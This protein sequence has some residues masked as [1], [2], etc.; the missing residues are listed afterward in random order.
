MYGKIRKKEK[1]YGKT[2]KYG[3]VQIRKYE[4]KEKNDILRKFC[5]IGIFTKIRSFKTLVPVL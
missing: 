5:N 3:N 2:R 4:N 1:M